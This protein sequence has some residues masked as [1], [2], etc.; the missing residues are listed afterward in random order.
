MNLFRFL[1]PLFLIAASVASA[2]TLAHFRTILGDLEVEL[3]D[4]DTPV[5]VQ[6]FIRYTQRG[7]YQATLIH[8]WA[9]GFVIQGGGFAAADLTNINAVF[10]LV[11]G[12]GTITNEFSLGRRYSNAYGTIA[13]AREGGKTNSATSQWFINLTNNAF[14]DDVDG[15]FTVFGRVVRGTNV[16]DRFNDLKVVNG[17]Y[18]NGI[19]QYQRE[20]PFSELP[21]LQVSTN[22]SV[23][24]LFITDI[25]LLNA[26]VRSDTDGSREISWNSVSNLVQHVE[27]TTNLP[28]TWQTL[29]STNGTGGALKVVDADTADAQRFYRVRVDY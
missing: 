25:T 2:G 12:F 10:P 17:V 26:Q 15:G 20:P 7:L 16:L 22:P 14:L 13:M 5:T 3:Y 9:P 23:F 11:T 29:A 21:I 27:F 1:P 6:N 8:R 18:T 4:Q 24:H 19:Y 28:P